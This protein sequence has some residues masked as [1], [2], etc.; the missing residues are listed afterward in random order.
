M[1]AFSEDAPEAKASLSSPSLF[2]LVEKIP[3]VLWTT[4]PDFRLTSLAG[5]GLAAMNIRPEDYVGVRLN[6][7]L[8][9]H[10]LDAPPLVAHQQALRGEALHV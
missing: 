8:S 1:G 9:F 3:A 7:F 5:A 4:N 2:L 6:D 10:E